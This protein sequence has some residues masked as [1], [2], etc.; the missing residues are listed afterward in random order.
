VLAC[1][2]PTV[3]TFNTDKAYLY[4]FSIQSF[5]GGGEGGQMALFNHRK[6]YVALRNDSIWSFAKD[7][8]IKVLTAVLLQIQAFWD[9]TMSLGD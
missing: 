1:A 4:L 2:W 9:D 3:N 8:R 5:L 6:R 7:A